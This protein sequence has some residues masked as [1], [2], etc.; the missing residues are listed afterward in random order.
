MSPAIGARYARVAALASIAALVAIGLYLGGFGDA[1][2]TVNDAA[3]LVMTLSLGP[4]MATFYELGG[5]TPLRPA[6]A[7]LAAGIAAVLVFSAIEV[8]VIARVVPLERRGPASGAFAVEALAI[9]VV[10]LWIAGADLLAGPWLPAAVRWLGV[11]TGL[12]TVAFAAGLLAGGFN[13][14]LAYAGGVA[15]QLLL[16]AWAW[17]LY[18]QW[19]SGTTPA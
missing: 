3:L 5:R 12:G 7:S 14:P 6:Q 8:L 13:H 19:R 18:R 10:G 9:A 17:L 16:P 1:F 15:Y 4:V 11:V 2:R